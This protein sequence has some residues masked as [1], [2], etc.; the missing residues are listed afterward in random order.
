MKKTEEENEE[1]KVYTM[2][3]FGVIYSAIQILDSIPPGVRKIR[4][5]ITNWF[6]STEKF[7]YN[8]I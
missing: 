7:I 4:N 2:L 5:S 6:W 8:S 3:I 1:W